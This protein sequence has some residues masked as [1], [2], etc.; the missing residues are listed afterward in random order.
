[1]IYLFFTVFFHHGCVGLAEIFNSRQLNKKELGYP[2]DLF[3]LS[4]T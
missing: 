3:S 1:M 4:R 2:I